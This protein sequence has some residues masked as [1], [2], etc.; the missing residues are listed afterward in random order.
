MAK[1][2]IN[3]GS[4][5]NDGTGDPNRTAFQKINANFTELYDGQAPA[6]LI[7]TDPDNAIELG[8]DGKLWSGSTPDATTTVKGKLKLAG[9]LAG[10]ADLPTVPALALKQDTLTDV[11]FGAFMNART[12]KNTLVDADEVVS[13]D[14]ADSNKAKKTTWL[15]VWNNYIKVKADVLYQAILTDINFGSFSTSLTSKTT[16]IDDDTINL[17]DSADS[18]K[19][20]KLSFANLKAWI[21]RLINTTI[22]SETGVYYFNDLFGAMTAAAD[23][24]ISSRA[25]GFNSNVNFTT[26]TIPNHQV[27]QSGVAQLKTGTTATGVAG[28]HIGEPIYESSLVVGGGV[29][30]YKTSINI[31]TLSTASERFWVGVGYNNGVF[32]NVGLSNA[33]CFI[34]DEGGVITGNTASPNW[35]IV[36]CNSS[37]RTFTDTGVAVSAGAWVK[38]EIL[39]NAAATSVEFF[40][41][42][43]SVGTIS[44]N[45]PSGISKAMIINNQILKTIGTTSRNL[46]MDYVAYKQTFTTPRI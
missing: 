46:Y 39:I 41:N 17:S 35:K 13:D 6:N 29:I 38:L 15:N 30:S 16:P 2:T 11:N 26:G 28:I 34:Y 45:I 1:Q 9:D 44:T 3:V 22:T 18:N 21:F 5:A 43:V 32:M 36:T 10:T 25:I 27:N 14:S 24:Y 19:A 4:S 40:I 37:V 20:K 12:A 31:G 42:N 8:S 7:S 33:I 23:G